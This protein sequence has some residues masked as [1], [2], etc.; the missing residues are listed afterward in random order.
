MAPT[1]A[2]G[3]GGGGGSEEEDDTMERDHGPMGFV[4]VG[5]VV[6]VGA[7]VLAAATC[8]AHVLYDV[9]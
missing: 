5:E 2:V 6:V 9:L 8:Y 7:V 3:K 1:D 4:R